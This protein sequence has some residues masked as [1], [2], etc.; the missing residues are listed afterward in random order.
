[1]KQAMRKQDFEYIFSSLK[2]KRSIFKPSQKPT[3]KVDE[4]L[5][6]SSKWKAGGREGSRY[7]T[8]STLAMLTG[9]ML[10]PSSPVSPALSSF[11]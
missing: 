11:S 10:F 5:C 8:P 6:V 7:L 1:M 4:A 9:L 2:Q 3:F